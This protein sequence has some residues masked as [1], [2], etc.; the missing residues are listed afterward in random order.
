MHGGLQIVGRH[1]KNGRRKPCGR[2]VQ[3]ELESRS[4]PV[5]ARRALDHLLKNAGDAAFGT[6]IGRL[7]VRHE[8]SAAAFNAACKYAV[9]RA[10]ADRAMG[11]PARN[12]KALQYEAARG[13]SLIADDPE[14]EIEAVAALDKADAVVGL[15]SKELSALLDVVVYDETPHDYAH[16]LAMKA[17]LEK[18]V[19]HWRLVD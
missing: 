14:R 11:L 16:K 6:T 8:I 4:G 10:R 19:A 1:R 17:A 13:L 3:D 12:P 2:L 18:L 7:F 15:H 5:H 9:L